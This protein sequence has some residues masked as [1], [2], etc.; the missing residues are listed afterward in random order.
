MVWAYV[1]NDMLRFKRLSKCVR[2]CGLGA[3]HAHASIEFCKTFLLAH[4]KLENSLKN[5]SKN[6]KAAAHPVSHRFFWSFVSVWR[7]N[8]VHGVASFFL[9]KCTRHRSGY[10]HGVF[11]LC[12]ELL[13][14]F[15]FA[16]KHPKDASFFCIVGQAASIYPILSPGIFF[17]L[18]SFLQS[19]FWE[20]QALVDDGS[21]VQIAMA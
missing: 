16:R 12:L 5:S 8:G 13:R 21:K 7:R 2:N 18:T 4:S 20:E 11:F 1:R 14:F 10:L 6:C 19:T 3:S 17:V 15:M 9:M